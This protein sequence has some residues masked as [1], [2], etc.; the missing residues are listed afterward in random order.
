MAIPGKLKLIG[1]ELKSHSPFKLIGAATGIVFML[2]GQQWF[3]DRAETLFS[4]F[5][6]LHVILSA[7]VT[8]ALFEIPR[9]AKNF[10][11]VLLLT[12]MRCRRRL[13]RRDSAV[14]FSALAV[15]PKKSV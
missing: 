2:V 13:S 12:L 9:K 11:V 10:M 15:S 14:A 1:S 6:P 4:V 5:H 7:M 8:T 3:A